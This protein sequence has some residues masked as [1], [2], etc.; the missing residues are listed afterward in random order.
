MCDKECKAGHRGSKSI[1]GKCEGLLC[2]CSY[3]E[4]L[5]CHTDDC[6]HS[7]DKKFPNREGVSAHCN[8]N[9]CLCSYTKPCDFLSCLSSCRDKYSR[10]KYKL[11]EASCSD[12]FS[13]CHCEVELRCSVDRCRALCEKQKTSGKKITK[14]G[15]L[16]GECYCKWEEEKPKGRKRFLSKKKNKEEEEEEE[17]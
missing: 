17:D 4:H 13:K 12:D 16:K 15:C 8:I 5:D 3:V 7:C 6:R 1:A 14:V 11:K 9:K 2:K 10:W